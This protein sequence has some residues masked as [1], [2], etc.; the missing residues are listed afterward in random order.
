M[1][2]LQVI[3][4]C[5]TLSI[6]MRENVPAAEQGASLMQVSEELAMLKE[7]WI[8][9]VTLSLLVSEKAMPTC[10]EDID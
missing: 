7:T 5:L 1:S 3:W 9:E 6:L 8:G 2:C 10:I 4:R